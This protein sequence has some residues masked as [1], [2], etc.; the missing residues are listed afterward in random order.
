MHILIVDD[1]AFVCA[2]LKATLID[3]LDDVEVTSHRARARKFSLFLPKN[4]IDLNNFGSLYAYGGYAVA[5]ALLR[6]LA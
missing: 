2:G 5:S 3:T 6:L 1:H 4:D